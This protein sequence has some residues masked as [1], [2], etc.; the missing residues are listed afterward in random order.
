[1]TMLSLKRVL[2]MPLPR[3]V[4][5]RHH[6]HAPSHVAYLQIG[7]HSQQIENMQR[8]RE[9]LN[10]YIQELDEKDRE[11]QQLLQQQQTE[12][13]ISLEELYPTRTNAIRTTSARGGSQQRQGP[14]G[15]GN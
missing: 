2:T 8:E 1:M 7:A 3:C 5:S 15:Y 10:V 11:Q 14:A 6:T 13:S 9:V 12:V 4:L